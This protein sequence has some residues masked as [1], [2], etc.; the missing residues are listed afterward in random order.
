MITSRRSN[1]ACVAAWRSLSISSLRLSPSRCTC[2]T[3][4]G[5]P[6]AGSSRS[7]SRSTRPR[8]P[9][10]TPGT[11]VELGRERLVVGQHERRLAVPLDASG[12]RE[13]L[14]RAGRARAASGGAGPWPGR[15]PGARSPAAGHRWAGSRRRAGSRASV[16]D[17][18]L[19]NTVRTRDARRPV[20]RV[21]HRCIRP[22]ERDARRD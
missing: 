8:C 3:G 11:R 5:T 9:G 10:R 14:A 1:S 4:A 7:S 20:G 12:D 16:K 19:P 15:R 21:A 6:R 2:P 17:T 18:R 13:R 22:Y